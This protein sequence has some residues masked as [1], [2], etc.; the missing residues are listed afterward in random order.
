LFLGTSIEQALVRGI[1]NAVSVIS[2][3]NTKDELLTQ[4]ELAKQFKKISTSD[5]QEFPLH[6]S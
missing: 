4:N 3:I 5:V 1:I 6:S 2:Y